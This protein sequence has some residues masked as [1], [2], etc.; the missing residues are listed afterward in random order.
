LAEW[1]ETE[2][3]IK[4]GGRI[5]LMEA[6]N[7]EKTKKVNFVHFFTFLLFYFFTFLLFWKKGES[8]VLKFTYFRSLAV[9]A[10]P[11]CQQKLLHF[12]FCQAVNA[13]C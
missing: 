7:N 12:L 10:I 13:S 3:E 2:A 5:S 9:N 4:A 8:C 11:S 6:G 1:R